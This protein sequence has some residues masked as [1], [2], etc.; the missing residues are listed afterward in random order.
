VQVDGN[1][2][3][4]VRDVVAGALDAAR[5]GAG[6]SLIE[7][8]TYRLSDHTTADDA[9]RYR[10]AEEVA[11]AWRLEPLLR[12]RR[13]LAGIGLWDDAQEQALLEDSARAVDAAVGEYLA[14]AKETTDA[15]FEHLFAALP[16][17][18]QEQRLMARR[19]GTK[20][21]H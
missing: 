7:A 12:L 11:R 13:Y 21:S 19:Y 3:F 9:G 1:D 14:T 17:R 5:S 18:L 16:A 2:A 15:M 4:G 10:S 6:P 8:L 20:P